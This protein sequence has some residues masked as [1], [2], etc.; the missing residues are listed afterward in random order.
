MGTFVRAPRIAELLQKGPSPELSQA[1]KVKYGDELGGE[2]SRQ[3]RTNKGIKTEAA[4]VKA[5]AAKIAERTQY[6]SSSKSS[7]GSGLLNVKGTTVSNIQ[8][9]TGGGFRA[10]DPARWHVHF[11]HVKWGTSTNTRINFKGRKK[12]AILAALVAQQPL[13]TSVD[14]PSWDACHQWIQQNL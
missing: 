14:W 5:A 8:H 11:D 10:G 2:M 13:R 4:L 7:I 9:G 12:Q 3:L 1:L 6:A